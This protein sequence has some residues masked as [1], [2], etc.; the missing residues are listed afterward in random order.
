MLTTI[1][2]FA[3]AFG[4]RFGLD[5]YVGKWC[6]WSDFKDY[7]LAFERDGQKVE[8]WVGPLNIAICRV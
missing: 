5:F 8:L 3:N 2:T 6:R 1:E 7:N 4:H